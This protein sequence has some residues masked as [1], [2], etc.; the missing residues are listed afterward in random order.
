MRHPRT[1]LIVILLAAGLSHPAAGQLASR[2]A[3]EWIKTLESPGRVADLRIDEVIGRLGL[4][5]GDVV[6]D[7]GAGAGVFSVPLARAVGPTGKVYAVEIDQALVDHISRKA[8][9]QKAGNVRAI[10]GTFTDPALPSADVDVAFFHDV[11]HHIEDRPG[12]LKQV[13]RYLKPAGRFAIVELDAETGAHRNDPKLQITKDQLKSWLAD[14]GFVQ[15]AEYRLAQPSGTW[16]TA[17]PGRPRLA[18]AVNPDFT[19]R[20]SQ[21]H[22]RPVDCGVLR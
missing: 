22:H 21:R 10:L 3:D 19:H 9:D 4:K 5:P 17:E 6:A 16:C 8:S 13:T 20:S 2:S 15:T 12:Y 11:V 18:Q 14:L 1:G 7:L